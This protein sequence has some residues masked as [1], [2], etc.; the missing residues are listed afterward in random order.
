M[1]LRSIL[2][3]LLTCC[4]LCRSQGQTVFLSADS[5]KGK[6]GEYALTKK[7]WHFINSDQPKWANPAIDDH[8]WAAVPTNFGEANPLAGWKGIGWFR[9]WIQIDT[10]LTQK[11]LG[12]RIN[13]DGASEIYIDGEYLG[14]YGTIGHSKA[15]TRIAREPFKVLPVIIKDARPHLIAIR[16]ANF[17]HVFPDFIG[18]QTWLGDYQKLSAAKQRDESLYE[19][20]WLSVAAQLSLALL[21]LFL[22]FFYPKQRL[23][24]YYVIFSV[25][26]AGTTLAVSGDNITANPVMQW[27]WQHIFWICGV[28]G[29][30][31]GWYL[32]YAVGQ[33][34]IP[35]WKAIFIF[36]FLVVYLTKKVLFMDSRPYNDGFSLFFLIILLDGIWALIVAIRRGLPHIWLI[37]LGMLLI[38]LFYFFIG[39]DVFRL[40]ANGAERSLA[41][42]IG[43]FSFPV[44]FSI[45]LALNFARTNQDLS[46]RLLEV[47][48]LSARA[49]AQ[50]SEKLELITRQAENLE[51]TVAER[52]AQVQSQADRL[53]ELDELKSRFFI[54]L[55][56]EF[57]TPLTLILGPA[58]QLLA[59]E[60]ASE[61]RDGIQTIERNADKLLQL[62]NQLL[63][64]SKLEAGKM[65][66]NNTS[67]EVVSLVNS[68]VQLFKSLAGQKQITLHF[69]SLVNKCWIA[70]DQ[71]KLERILYNLLSNAIKFTNSKGNIT[72]ELSIAD[73]MLN[74]HISDTGIGISKDKLPYIFDRFYQVDASDTRSQEGSGI[75]LA[76]TR[77]LVTLMGGNI[78]ITSEQELG[79]QVQLHLPITLADADEG[80][81]LPGLSLLDGH[82]EEI[83]TDHD[84]GT[85]LPV[86]LLVED[87]AD[88]RHFIA[89]VFKDGYQLI[90]AS[91]GEHGLSLG[92][93]HIP[94][95]VITDLMM[96]V[97]DGYEVCSKL[98]ANEKTSHIPIVLLTAKSDTDSRILGLEN[99]ADAYLTKPF[100]QREL[101]ATVN[102]LIALR[103]RLRDRYQKNI[104]QPWFIDI[105]ELPSMEQVFLDKVK[106]TIE[107][108]LTEESYS[109]DQLGVELGL[110]RTQLHRK[111]KALTGQGP[112]E[113]VRSFRL[114]RAYELLKNKTGTVAEVGYLVGFGNP[115][116]FST[117]FS[118]YFGFSPSEA[119]SQ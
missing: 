93:A 51:Q 78:Y 114:Q 9:L 36:G 33:T 112:G 94:D 39:A 75:G 85:D 109:V 49:L 71:P 41:M 82:E 27:W 100:D 73:N 30:A 31:S 44:L 79:T 43:I 113:L 42:S 104:P 107:I 56:H 35:K 103:R 110:S 29:T 23:N 70:L 10:T 59:G 95:L 83:I 11:P 99:Q 89:S 81:I 102:N 118:K 69:S 24:L 72:V 22:F 18:F 115:N 74:L 17:G 91:D 64:L 111:L 4:F 54:N 101:L 1:Q 92:L 88:L 53:S 57:R 84:A 80:L 37:G 117:S 50:E 68:H 6:S 48:E 5:L 8:G 13:H 28:I 60:I 67:L 12:L 19:Y 45:Y 119:A 62:I 116:S 21:H 15:D 97:M 47:E 106:K 2:L 96:P 38:V 76:I 46:L 90:E 14:D 87:N 3:V 52:T 61:L 26:F 58:R 77:E 55:T 63:D 105:E 40:W 34:R 32:L 98:K 7:Q 16:Y 65:Q 108:H 86:I 66:L 25:L 20:M